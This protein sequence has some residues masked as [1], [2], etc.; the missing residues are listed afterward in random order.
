MFLVIDMFHLTPAT[1]LWRD[2]IYDLRLRRMYS[3]KYNK[4]LNKYSIKY[5]LVRNS[6]TNSTANE[7]DWEA[8][9]IEKITS[10]QGH[11]DS[12][13]PAGEAR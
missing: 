12:Y 8:T 2:R 5:L 4:N 7:L 6:V 9:I 1:A 10:I 13:I 3:Y 11:A